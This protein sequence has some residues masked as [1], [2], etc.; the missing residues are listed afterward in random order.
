[1]KKD[2]NLAV[3]VGKEALKSFSQTTGVFLFTEAVSYFIPLKR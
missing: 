2:V 1:M 3:A